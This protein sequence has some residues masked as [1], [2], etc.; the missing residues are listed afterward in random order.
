MPF[1]LPKL[2]YAEDALAP[3]ISSNTMQF[4]HGKHHAAYVTKLNTLIEGTAYE[5][6]TL[7][8]IIKESH[9]KDADKAIFNNAAQTWNHTFFWHSMS[10]TGGGKARDAAAE[11]LQDLGGPDKFREEFLKAATGQFGS[12]WAW[13]VLERGKP[14]IVATANAMTPIAEDQV[15]LLTCDVWEHA[16]YLDYQNRR[17]SFVAAFVDHLVNWNLV[18]AQLQKAA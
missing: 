13:L 1:T 14:K 3:H 16:Y 18:A 6:K 11:L 9:G 10:P 17:E 8:Q 12:G 2:P 15:P 7:E 5:G 4:H